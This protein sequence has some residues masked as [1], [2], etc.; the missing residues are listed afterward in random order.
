MSPSLSTNYVLIGSND[1]ICFPST[2]VSILVT[3]CAIGIEELYNDQANIYPN[4]TSGLV[5][6]ELPLPSA[7]TYIEIRDALGK[8]VL[9]EE[10][11]YA[12][13]T[14]NI[15]GLANGLYFYKVIQSAA[16]ISV[17]KIQKQ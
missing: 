4:P 11:K 6:I 5:A 7:F 13:N 9:K 17:G 1:G 10:L 3:P 2:N 12:N 8:L 14:L 16:S 15:E